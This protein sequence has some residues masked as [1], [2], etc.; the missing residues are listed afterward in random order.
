MMESLALLPNPPYLHPK[1]G[2]YHTF[3]WPI[4]HF[5]EICRHF[6]VGWHPQLFYLPLHQRVGKVPCRLLELLLP[7]FRIS[8]SKPMNIRRYMIFFINF[9]DLKNLGEST[10][11]HKLF[12]KIVG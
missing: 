7:L 6:Y 10:N 4:W 12:D 9:S 5:P 1:R 2:N 11:I 3:R 8:K